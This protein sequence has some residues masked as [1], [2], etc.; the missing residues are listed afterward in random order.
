MCIE[1]FE[2]QQGCVSR[3]PGTELKPGSR[4]RL[5]L[6]G[7]SLPSTS[8]GKQQHQ[9]PPFPRCPCFSICGG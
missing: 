5:A 1:H 7:V 4:F 6:E 9:V 8:Q 3:E 2:I